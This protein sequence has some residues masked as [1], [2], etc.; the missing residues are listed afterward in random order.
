MLIWID[1][2]LVQSFY[3]PSLSLSL[4][5]GLMSSVAFVL[6]ALLLLSICLDL[7]NKKKNMTLH[8]FKAASTLPAHSQGPR[9]VINGLL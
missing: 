8:Q 6:L 2:H 5:L 1:E 4:P 7:R 3:P 9:V